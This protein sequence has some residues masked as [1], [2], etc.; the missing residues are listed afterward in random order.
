MGTMMSQNK[1]ENVM[2]QPCHVHFVGIGGISMSGLAEILL[3]NGY[4]V[5]GS[6]ARESETTRKLIS[7]GADVYYGHSRDNITDDI[8]YL[9]YTAAVKEDNPE[10]AAAQ[11][12]GIPTITRA[13]L[14]GRIMEQYKTAISVAGTH[15]KTTTTSMI[16]EIMLAYQCD[17]TILVGGMLKTIGGNL[18]VGHSDYLVTE[19]CEYTNSFLSLI[20]NVN[21]ILNVR[22]DHLDFFKDIND[23]R[24]SFKIFAEKPDENGTLIINSGIENLSY[25]TNGLKCTYRTFGLNSKTSDYSPANIVYNEFACASFDVE[26][27]VIKCAGGSCY[28]AGTET[29]AHIDLKVP[30]EHNILNALAAFATAAAI[31]IPV[32]YIVKGLNNYAGTDRRFQ[33]K[34]CFGGVNVIDDYAHHPDEIKATLTAAKNYPHNNIWCVFQPHT[35]TRTKAL[36]TEFAKALALADKVVL[37]K[38]Y[39][40]RETDTLGISSENLRQEIAK[41]GKEVYYFETFEEIEKFLSK[42]CINDDLL[43]TMGAGD[44][45]LIGENLVNQ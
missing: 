44:V 16:A 30:G 5:S 40:A 35:Y 42:K 15:G 17:P 32:E 4:T 25:F 31:K 13:M 38:I 20:S 39:P 43:I 36:M 37:A 14:L 8:S 28:A 7:L 29:V 27:R 41:S 23:I 1:I 19:A 26:K 45:V 2:R 3:D 18:R 9:V 34:G 24:H 21:V 11:D 12:K 33:Y 22:E 6:D 10:L